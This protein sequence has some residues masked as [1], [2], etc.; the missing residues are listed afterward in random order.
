MTDWAGVMEEV[1]KARA[2][3]LATL[4]RQ[5]S[6]LR[7]NLRKPLSIESRRIALKRRIRLDSP[8]FKGF[9]TE[10]SSNISMTGMFVRSQNPEPPGTL[11]DFELHLADGLQLIKGTAEVVWVR[12]ADDG[13]DRPGGMGLRFVRLDK[14]SRRVIRWAVEKHLREGGKAFELGKREPESGSI[15]TEEPARDEIGSVGDLDLVHPGAEEGADP[16]RLHPYAGVAVARSRFSRRRIAGVAAVGLFAAALFFVL[17][18][19]GED[20][21]TGDPRAHSA[22]AGTAP[23]VAKEPRAAEQPAAPEVFDTVAAWARAWS[24]QEVD[25]Y[26][27]FYATAYRPPGGMGRTAWSEVR[28]DRIS[29]PRRI[30]VGITELDARRLAPDRFRVSFLQHYDADHYSDRVR[31]VLELTLEDGRWKILEETTE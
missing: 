17:S 5:G 25:R 27:S 20:A 8:H 4:A 14:E 12:A 28:R 23:P 11:V 21:L 30:E 29:R 10:Y 31:K 1:P 13:P 22:P 19:R 6:E 15:V 24:A 7:H 16:G 26:L 3:A 9:L 2:D 18:N